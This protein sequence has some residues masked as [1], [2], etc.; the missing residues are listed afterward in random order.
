MTPKPYPKSKRKAQMNKRMTL[1]IGTVCVNGLFFCSDSEEGS[2]SGAKRQVNKLFAKRGS[3]WQM[4]IGGAGVGSLCDIAV[5]RIFAAADKRNDDFLA[6]HET[7]IGDEMR[8]IYEQ[9]IDKAPEW[10]RYDR[11]ISLVIGLLDFDTRNMLLYKTEQEILAPVQDQFACAGTGD[12]IANYYLDRLFHDFRPPT[13]SGSIP[14]L[15]E[16]EALLQY[17]MREAK[18]S[19]GGV[20]GNTKT[21]QVSF[22][23]NEGPCYGT[24]GVGWEGRQPELESLFHHFWLDEPNPTQ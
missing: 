22:A 17:V 12:T 16:A 24:F 10:K 23:R 1:I 3:S 13:M 8:K 4:I 18:Q 14:R 15:H 21:I 20:G 2:P 7:I 6:E 5:Q 11:D 19:T 9:Y